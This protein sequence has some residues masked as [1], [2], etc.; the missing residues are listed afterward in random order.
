MHAGQL[1]AN[2]RVETPEP[3]ERSE[4][5][6][7]QSEIFR[8]FG[9]LRRD[10]G[11]AR[12]GHALQK[13]FALYQASPTAFWLVQRI[14]EGDLDIIST[15]YAELGAEGCRSKQA[16]QQETERAMS[17]LDRHYP[18]AA[19]VIVQL[20]GMT[21]D[22]KSTGGGKIEP[23]TFQQRDSRIAANAGKKITGGA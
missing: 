13:M 22:F 7:I 4:E 23:G 16:V 14:M 18:T 1:S 17:V 6:A 3:T 5:A 21:A 2:L 11:R 15:S 9:D 8:L 10:V 12:A 20:F 19:A